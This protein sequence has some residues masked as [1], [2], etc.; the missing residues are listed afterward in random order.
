M[1]KFLIM[2]TWGIGDWLF[3]TPVLKALKD[4]YPGAQFDVIIGKPLTAKAVELYPEVN[5]RA[6][7]DTLKGSSGMV[8]A[9][10]SLRKNKY[11]AAL[12]TAGIDSKKAD[13]L[14]L[15]IR[16]E[17][18]YALKS[19][20]HRPHFLSGSL[21]FESG[22]HQVDNNLK[23]LDLMGVTRPESPAPYL[24]A[25]TAEKPV[26][27]SFLLHP[28]CDPRNAFKRWP[29]GKFSELAG[30]LLNSGRRV[31]V[32]LGPGEEDLE[33]F[34]T[35]LKS[36]D[37]FKLYNGR[38]LTEAI[39]IINGHEVFINTDSGLGHIAGALGKK[40][41][42]IFGPADPKKSRVYSKH[43]VTVMRADRLDCMPCVRP[44]GR[45]GCSEHRCLSQ[46]QAED[47]ISV[48]SENKILGDR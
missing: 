16:A 18:K 47:V 42:T 4:E 17:K 9:V 26:P 10:L 8:K 2:H 28:G 5:I 7:T 37:N 39:E 13:M 14:S 38:S 22:V 12:F 11:D 25:P 34:F 6:V 21:P 27:G 3:F 36:N 19:L 24:P 23:L 1:K 44:G 33:K 41:V 29:A 40:T 35:R 45:Y 43:A 32:I 15:L 30:K 31:S 20:K 46:I 48:M